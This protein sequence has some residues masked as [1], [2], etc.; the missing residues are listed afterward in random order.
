M[1]IYTKSKF[2]YGHNITLTNNTISLDE[3]SGDITV[4]LNVGRYSLTQFVVEVERAL[5]EFGN[6]TYTVTLDRADRIITI[7]APNAFDLLF[8]SGGS[9]GTSVYS[10]LGFEQLDYTGLNSYTAPN[11]SGKEYRPQFLLQ[12]YLDFKDNEESIQ[13]VVNES[14]QGVV[15]VVA[16][17][18]KRIMKCTITFITDIFQA[19]NAPIENNPTGVDDANDFLS[20]II[21]KGD[22]EFIPDRDDNSL[23]GFT[24]C[25]LESTQESKEG[26]AYTLKELFSKGLQGYYDTGELTF[27]AVN[28]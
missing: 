24:T 21:N 25:F 1:A 2:Y 14:A 6:Q 3:G 7:D 27:R 28:R 10:L 23:S 26:T 16:F 5:N 9:S 17:G 11:P 13:S 19:K 20:D 8:F 15:E 4:T 22:I 12:R 18:R